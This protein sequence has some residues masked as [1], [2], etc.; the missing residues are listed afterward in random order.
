MPIVHAIGMIARKSNMTRQL[1][2]R[3]DNSKA[4]AIRTTDVF[5]IWKPSAR[6]HCRTQVPPKRFKAATSRDRPYIVIESFHSH[7][8]GG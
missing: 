6:S 8:R 5:E 4:E 2:R 3:F 1:A 7:L